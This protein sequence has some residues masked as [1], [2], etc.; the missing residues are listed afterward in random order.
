MSTHTISPYELLGVHPGASADEMKNAYRRQA[1]QHHPDLN[2]N[3]REAAEEQFKLITEVCIRPRLRKHRSR[4]H[5]IEAKC[6]WLPD[7]RCG[8]CVSGV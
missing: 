1:L 4:K 3:N 2:P 7:I 6:L 8:A 5:S